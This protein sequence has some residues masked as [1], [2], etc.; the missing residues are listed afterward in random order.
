MRA[1]FFGTRG[2]TTVSG[3]DQ[4]RYGGYTSCVGLAHDA[5]GP[6]AGQQAGPPAGLQ[7]QAQPPTLVLDAGTGL[8]QLT[9]TLG[10]MPFR[11]SLLLGHLHWDHT[12]GMPFF[13][14]GLADGHRV[15]VY[16][17]EQGCD[18]EDLLARSMSPPHF[19]IR[20]KE[21]GSGWA[22]HALD[23][24]QHEIEGFGVRAEEIPHKGGRT[25]GYR[26]SAG[27]ATL[28]YLSDHSPLAYGPGPDGLG[29]YHPAAVALAAGADVLIHD[30]QHTA[31]EL[32]RLAF[33]GHSAVEYAVGLA[34]QCGV[35]T[36]VLFHHDP[37]RTDAEI[38]EILA[39]VS[40]PGIRVIAAYDGMVLEIP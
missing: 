28:A 36:L 9:K 13:R 6:Q 29:E 24:G 7:G 35:G 18:P 26:V 8:Q 25:F 1:Y 3:P 20:P 5:R 4:A 32:P 17:P 11:G 19:P 15:D 12:H 22:F 37:W 33:L 23:V 34:R 10:G 2:S 14:G 40:G 39:S 31:A 16:L 27:P 21:L 38:D 30:A